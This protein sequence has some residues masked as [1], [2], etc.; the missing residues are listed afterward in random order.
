MNNKKHTKKGFTLVELVIVIAIIG[1]LTM[2]VMVAWNRV[3][4]RQR[5]TDA[6]QR[7]KVIFN[8]AQT[9]CIKYSTTERNLDP[10]ERYVGTGDFYLYWNGGSA[11]SGDAA[12]N[13]PHADANDTRFAAAIN[14][15]LAENGTYKVYI[16]D[17]VVQ[18]VV[19]QERANNRFM[20]AYPAQRSDITNDTV[21]ACSDMVQYA[22]LVH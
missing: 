3:I 2:I 12:N 6:N 7:A 1:I 5:L 8:A 11:S 20:G 22:Q 14:R 17:Y 13:T 4:N 9:E 15:I 19:Y 16:R 21:A 10:D 18:S